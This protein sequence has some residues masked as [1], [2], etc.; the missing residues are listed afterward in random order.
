[1]AEESDAYD[2]E[3]MTMRPCIFVI[4]DDSIANPM[5]R[6]DGNSYHDWFVDQGY[7]DTVSEF[8]IIDTDPSTNV[9]TV[10]GT[11]KSYC[12]DFQESDCAYHHSGGLRKLQS[13]K[14]S[15]EVGGVGT[16]TLTFPPQSRR[17][18]GRNNNKR[19]LQQDDTFTSD[20]GI[21]INVLSREDG[22]ERMR[23]AGTCGIQKTSSVWAVVICTGFLL[24]NVLC[25]T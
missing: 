14:M 15:S 17:K 18:L 16:A 4:D 21:T 9:T 11:M 23:T 10:V 20:L 12:F 1:L 2:H 5:D 6:R 24:C 25:M 3:S 8:D 22:P 13:S 7:N 19:G